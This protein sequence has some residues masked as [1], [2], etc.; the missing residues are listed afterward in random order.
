MDRAV[1]RTGPLLLGLL[2]WLGGC[3]SVPPVPDVGGTHVA[4]GAAIHADDKTIGEMLTS[5][6]RA[7]QALRH[8]NLEALMDLYSETYRYHSLDKERLGNIWR[9]LFRD[10]RS[11]SS[12]H[13]F[14]KIRVEAGTPRPTAE[15]TCTGSL[16]AISKASGERVHID[17]WYNEVHYLVYEEGVWRIRGHAWETPEGPRFVISSHPFF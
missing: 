8:G 5:F 14:T 6:Y 9:E 11:F 2:L 7:D 1:T 3:Q 17:S 4:S 10:H 15:I 13:I 16:W 12:T